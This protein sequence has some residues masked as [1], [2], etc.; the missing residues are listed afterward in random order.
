MQV[1]SDRLVCDTQKK[2]F[3]KKLLWKATDDFED[4]DS[5]Y[6]EEAGKQCFK[7]L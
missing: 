4:T 6:D 3:T 1:A 2:N 7:V 5:D